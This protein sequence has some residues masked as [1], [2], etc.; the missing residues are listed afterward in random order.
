MSNNENNL[1]NTFFES[2][3]ILFDL[4]LRA[5]NIKNGYY[6]RNSLNSLVNFVDTN[7]LRFSNP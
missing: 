4:K 5:A 2:N 1:V 3:F 6:V 7:R